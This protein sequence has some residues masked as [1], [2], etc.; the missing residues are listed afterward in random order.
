MSYRCLDAP[1]GTRSMA[2]LTSGPM[3]TMV[4]LPVLSVSAG[5]KI[6]EAKRL[7]REW[8]ETHPQDGA[9]EGL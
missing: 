4:S 6:A 9:T 2:A 1:G 8:I 3:G 7:S 5:Q